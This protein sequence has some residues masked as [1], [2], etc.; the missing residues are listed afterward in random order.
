MR[1]SETILDTTRQT[2]VADSASPQGIHL[3]V[4]PK[5]SSRTLIDNS[6]ALG[7]EFSSLS[8]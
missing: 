4:C 6:T 2:L 8:A 3:S 7:R 1:S 5:F